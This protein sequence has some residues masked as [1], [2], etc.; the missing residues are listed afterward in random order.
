MVTIS[1]QF[2]VPMNTAVEPP[3]GNWAPLVDGVPRAVANMIWQ[4]PTVL[5]LQLEAGA[6][7]AVGVTI[8]YLAADPGL[9]STL[10]KQVQPFGPIPVLVL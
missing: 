8:E 5:D 4:S 1:L 6:P 2:S 9:R 3:F 7:V 10:S